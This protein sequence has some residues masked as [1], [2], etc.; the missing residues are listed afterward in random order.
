MSFTFFSIGIMVMI[1]VVGVTTIAF[2]A[3]VFFHVFK[4]FRRVDRIQAQIMDANDGSNQ[5][6]RSEKL[7]VA[8]GDVLRCRQC[9]AVIDST[10]EL[11][12][13]GAIRCNYCNSWTNIYSPGAN[14]GS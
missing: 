4:T 7:Q 11:S 5:S 9:G 12:P 3:F 14:T 13:E 8:T 2:V 1:A 10:A 6:S